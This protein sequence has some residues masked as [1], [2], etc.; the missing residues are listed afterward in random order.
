M[1]KTSLATVTSCMFS[2]CVILNTQEASAFSQ[3]KIPIARV[4]P[5][6]ISKS[7]LAAGTYSNSNCDADCSCPSCQKAHNDSC[8]CAN[9]RVTPMAACDCPDCNRTH[10]SAC[11]CTACSRAAHGIGCD[12][13]NCKL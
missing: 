2:Y 6:A 3:L 10:G 13:D 1:T 8:S 11:P 5:A 9:C 4:S 7:S 12:C